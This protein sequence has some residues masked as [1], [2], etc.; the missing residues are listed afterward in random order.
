LQ[1]KKIEDLIK[2]NTSIQEKLKELGANIGPEGKQM[3]DTVTSKLRN[4]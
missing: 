3:N 1:E 4:E 2:I